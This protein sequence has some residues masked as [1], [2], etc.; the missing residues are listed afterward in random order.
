LHKIK[1]KM[2]KLNGRLL[3]KIF[4]NLKNKKFF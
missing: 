1:S 3:E 2:G 4:K